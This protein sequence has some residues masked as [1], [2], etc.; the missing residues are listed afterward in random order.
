LSESGSTLVALQ[1]NLVDQLRDPL[2]LTSHAITHHP[3]NFSGESTRSKLSRVR[4]AISSPP[5]PGIASLDRSSPLNVARSAYVYLL[6]ALPT[7]AWLLNFRCDGDIPYCPTTLAYVA[8]TAD[9]CVVFVDGDRVS[10][11][12]K[13]D[14]KDAGVTTETYGVK[15]VGKWIQGYVTKK[16]ARADGEKGSKRGIKLLGAPECSWA[17]SRACEPVSTPNRMKRYPV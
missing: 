5:A 16:Q 17:L 1:E 4:A 3:I 12:V 2:P 14:W 7:I 6:P 15:S 8:I 10:E 11:E 13:Q 9:E